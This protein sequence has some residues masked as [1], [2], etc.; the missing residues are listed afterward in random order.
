MKALIYHEL[1]QDFEIDETGIHI[2]EID[3]LRKHNRY[4]AY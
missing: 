2:G 1:K 4:S 3:A